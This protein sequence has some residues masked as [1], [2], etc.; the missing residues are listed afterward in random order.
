MSAVLRTPTLLLLGWTLVLALWQTA[1]L[2]VAAKVAFHLVRRVSPSQRHCIASV[3]LALSLVL[4]GATFGAL[5]H[6]SPATAA[7]AGSAPVG[8]ARLHP[9]ALGSY[10][11]AGATPAAPHWPVE[12]IAVGWLVVATVL[13]VRLAGG[14][15]LVA[16]I[17]R[18]ATPLVS[19]PVVDTAARLNERLGLR[20]LVE[21]LESDEVTV[22]VT[23]G[24]RRPALLVPRRLEEILLPVQ[25]APV[26]AHELEHVRRRDQGVSLAQAVLDALLFFCP[27]AF[28]LSSQVRLAREERC[29]DMAVQVCGDAT[30]Y[31]G[32]LAVLAS[33]DH[34]LR[35]AGVL[36]LG[37][38]G[39]AQRVRRV[40]KGEAMPKLTSLQTAGLCAGFMLVLTSGAFV[41]AASVAETEPARATGDGGAANEQHVPIAFLPAQLGAPMSI[42]RASGTADHVFGGARVRNV[43][44]ARIV[45]VT[46]VA[47]VEAQ[48]HEARAILVESAPIGVGL[49]PGEAGE[50]TMPLLPV[51]Q[52][53][54][55]ERTR[56]VRGQGTL[57]ILEVQFADGSSW[58]VTPRDGALD[59]SQALHVPSA[60]VSR[61][62]IGAAAREASNGLCRDDL[63]LGYSEGAEI[64]IGEGGSSM[65]KCVR[66]SWTEKP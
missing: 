17:R 25:L 34:S 28:W 58:K 14:L 38:P 66:G 40:L 6:A 33:R 2:A 27:G 31:A 9:T 37:E 39:L 62:M 16:A 12:W 7:T 8:L 60:W 13:L 15:A 22:P 41:L 65:A 45:A 3:G 54:E 24:W 61:S 18:R 57:G 11:G 55:W 44:E 35:M 46:F 64:P 52:L 10:H 53:R 4:A 26:I 23:I 50:V 59:A 47:V 21:V 30:L 43:S 19:G 1:L 56:G 29:D 42:T 51:P 32:A 63:G 20:S 48:N 5:G 49:N 36:G